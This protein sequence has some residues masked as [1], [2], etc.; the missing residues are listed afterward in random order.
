[1]SRSE[2][3][4]HLDLLALDSL[5]AGGGTEGDRAHLEAC[6]SCRKKLQEL[7][8]L[9]GEIRSSLP[10]VVGV[11]PEIDRAI[12]TL[13]RKELVKGT[14]RG[15]FHLPVW[16]RAAAAILVVAALGIWITTWDGIPLLTRWDP[17]DVDRSGSVD[18]VDAYVL[19]L[20]INGGDPLKYSWDMNQDG[21]VDRRDV[22]EI[23]K[24][25]V[26]ISKGGPQ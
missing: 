15:L 19:A 11:P 21:A 25:C 14:R 16:V 2:P 22:D 24:E 20:R 18:I 3:E 5:R 26:S 7:E 9:A 17:R 8:R 23:A 1:M 6:G 4:T 12:M 10:E 13:A